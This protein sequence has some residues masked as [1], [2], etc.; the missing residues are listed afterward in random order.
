MKYV[1]LL[2]LVATPLSCYLCYIGIPAEHTAARLI[3]V[4]A[5]FVLS[6]VLGLCSLNSH[7]EKVDEE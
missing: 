5:L 6:I 2:L 4:V 7:P 1:K 3:V